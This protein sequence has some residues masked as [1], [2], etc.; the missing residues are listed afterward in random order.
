MSNGP[1][2]GYRQ[3]LAL[4]VEQLGRRQK[5]QHVDLARA[6]K[7]EAL[8][9]GITL[10]P[11]DVLEWVREAMWDCLLKRLII[12]G[13]DDANPNW[14]FYRLTE[15]GRIALQNAT[16]Q[17]YD[18]DGFLAYF[19]KTCVGVD[20]DVRGYVEEALQAYNAGCVRSAAVMLGCASEKLILL[21][22]EAFEAAISDATKKVTFSKDINAKWMIAHKYATIKSRLDLMKTAKKLPQEHA[23]TVASELVAGFEILRRCRNAAGHPEVPGNVDSDTVFLNLRAFTE[24]AR[25]VQALI[26]HFGGN[27][28]DW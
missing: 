21:L 16:P 22:C 15:H 6:V 23:D 8:R 4:T 11:A 14:P 10:P 13:Q 2:S 28:A 26:Q 9:R 25:R 19:D 12:F 24:Y 7:E 5:G 20:K 1:V 3:V 18:P 27:P 17:P